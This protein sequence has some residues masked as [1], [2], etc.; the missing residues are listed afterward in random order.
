MS[1]QR[2]NITVDPAVVERARRYTERHGTSI[3]R[4]VTEYLA[5][6][7]ME[8]G[9]E[10]GERLTPTVRRLLGAARGGGDREDYR[11]HLVEKYGR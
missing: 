1:K 8:A 9:V 4:L 11:R 7:P 2:I 6:L 3:S 5:Q 10:A